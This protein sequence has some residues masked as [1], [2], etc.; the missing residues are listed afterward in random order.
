MEV[1]KDWYGKEI[2]INKTLRDKYIDHKW[3]QSCDKFCRDWD[4]MSFDPNYPSKT[5]KYFEPLI[6][7]I[8]S[9][10]PFDPQYVGNPEFDYN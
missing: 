7:E 2:G 8:F 1:P 4:Q 10:E 5:L 6:N 3:Y 9:R